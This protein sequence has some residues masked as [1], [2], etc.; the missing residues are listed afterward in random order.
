M[1]HRSSFLNRFYKDTGGIAAIE[2]ALLMPIL[3]LVMVNVVSLYDGYRAN[4]SVSN[5][6]IVL[7]D[8]VSRNLGGLDNDDFAQ[9]FAVGTAT[10]G[11]HAIDSNFTMAIASVE[12]VIN[13]GNNDNETLIWS[14]SNS[15]GSEFT[16]AD[17]DDLNL[18]DIPAG[19]S[20]IVVQ[21]DAQYAPILVSELLG[22]FSLSDTMIYRPRFVNAVECREGC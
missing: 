17:I 2:F 21:V 11:Q 16:Q 14:R 9:L 1:T 6:A 12:N 10:A 20:V 19:N 7:G 18:P 4:M 15:P 8:L 5:T 3:M 22:S 13:E